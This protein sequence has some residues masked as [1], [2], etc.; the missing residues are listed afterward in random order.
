MFHACCPPAF[1]KPCLGIPRLLPRSCAGARA[2]LPAGPHF[3]TTDRAGA[4]PV[5]PAPVPTP[6]AAW[7][8]TQ[9]PA[10]TETS[11]LPC[12][13]S[14]ACSLSPASSALLSEQAPSPSSPSLALGVPSWLQL[15]PGSRHGAGACPWGAQ[16]GFTAS[17]AFFIPSLLLCSQPAQLPV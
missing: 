6:A 2:L 5:P 7:P 12:P 3:S 4:A 17:S 16:A 14:P 10:C 9:L 13:P 8:L 1:L 11:R 15:Q